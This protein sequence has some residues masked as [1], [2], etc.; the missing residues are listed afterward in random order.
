MFVL[1]EPKIEVP[2]GIETCDRLAEE[3][4][5][6]TEKLVNLR[7]LLS[8]ICKE[9]LNIQIRVALPHED[10]Q[11]CAVAAARDSQYVPLGRRGHGLAPDD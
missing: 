7:Q 11:R 4:F 5:Q 1:A 3:A 6:T 10:G 2:V 8:R 9:I